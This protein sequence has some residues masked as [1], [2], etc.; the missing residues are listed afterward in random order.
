VKVLGQPDVRDAL[1]REG[2]EPIGDTPEQF[3]G[4]IRSEL[5]RY[6]KLVKLAGIQAN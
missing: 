5:A 6:A 1:G 2:Y 3:A 4:L